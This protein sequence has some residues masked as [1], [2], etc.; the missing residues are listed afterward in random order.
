MALSLN[1]WRRFTSN[2][3]PID[4]SLLG[5]PG[6]DRLEGIVNVFEKPEKVAAIF[7]RNLDEHELPQGTVVTWAMFGRSVIKQT[8]P[9]QQPAGVIMATSVLPNDLCWV[10]MSNFALDSTRAASQ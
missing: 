4:H 9:D 8:L 2:L 10:A 6:F 1:L 5:K 3:I 7:V